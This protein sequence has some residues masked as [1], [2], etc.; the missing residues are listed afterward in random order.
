[1]NLGSYE[2]YNY[3]SERLKDLQTDFEFCKLIDTSNAVFEDQIFWG[4]FEGSPLQG[5]EPKFGTSHQ[6]S[7]PLLRLKSI[8]R[9]S[10]KWVKNCTCT[11]G[12]GTNLD[13]VPFCFTMKFHL[14]AFQNRKN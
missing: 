14:Q 12:A 7:T 13:I 6:D 10:V 11:K 5:E 3:K 4:L 9:Y 1:M 8:K 2:T